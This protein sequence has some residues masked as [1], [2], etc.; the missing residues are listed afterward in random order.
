MARRSK[1]GKAD[2]ALYPF[3]FLLAGTLTAGTV[4]LLVSPN[5]NFS[6]R[7]FVE[8]DSWAHFRIKALSFRIHPLNAVTN[9]QAAGYCGG[10][11]D[12]PPGTLAAVSELIPSCILG[13]RTTRPSDWVRVPK[14]D[15]AGP[16]PWY[17]TIPGNADATEEAPGTIT[18]I[19]TGTDGY[20]LEL[21][22]MFEFKT[23]V[24]T[25][26]T[27][28][29]KQLQE[30]VRKEKISSVM[31]AERALLLKILSTPSDATEGVK[32]PKSILS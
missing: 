28:L 5:S 27:P 12:T 13:G 26:N 25:A 8:A 2:S 9:A 16:L 29:A 17:K 20:Q 32:L 3:H 4:T 11:Q 14:S 15:L 18:V 31:S 7:A 30:L 6:P 23:A 10:I 19:G 21:R 1:N 22:G 24:A